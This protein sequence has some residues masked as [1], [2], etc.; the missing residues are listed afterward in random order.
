VRALTNEQ[1]GRITDPPTEGS[2]TLGATAEIVDA[3]GNRCAVATATFV[4]LGEA[5]AADAAGV[6]ATL[7][8]PTW[9]RS[10]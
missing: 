3:E 7:L 5:Q 2:S 9:T 4:I 1:W 6:D 8:D 10:E